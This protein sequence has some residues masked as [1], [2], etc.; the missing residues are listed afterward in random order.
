MYKIDSFLRETQR[1]DDPGWFTLA[2]PW[3][4]MYYFPFS[5]SLTRLALHPFTFSNGVTV[6][7]GTIIAVPNGAVH[8]DGENYPNPEEFDGFRFA[9]LRERDGVDVTRHQALSTSADHLTFGYGRRAWCVFLFLPRPICRL[10]SSI[11]PGR[12]FVVNEIKALVGHVIV[13]YDIKF[14]EGKQA[15]CGIHIG[16]MRI[17]GKANA[18][19][20]KRQR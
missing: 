10:Y 19:F 15:P 13:T 14:E 20:R 16:S 18:M 8:K 2:E 7:A 6:P 3:L 11:S 12:F 1:V 4:P 17:P 5:A 9:K